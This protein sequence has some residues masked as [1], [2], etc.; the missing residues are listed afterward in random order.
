MEQ[1]QVETTSDVDKVFSQGEEGIKQQ[2]AIKAIGLVKPLLEDCNTEISKYL[3]NCDKAIYI[4]KTSE[5]S[6]V[7]I[8]VLDANGKFEIK[9]GGLS[10]SGKLEFRGTKSAQLKYYTAE[11]FVE[12]LLTGRLKEL[13]EKLLK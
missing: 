11:E 9:G 4:T 8:T 3:G 5:D 12:L 10:A 6:P 2:V 7:G 1:D 13:T